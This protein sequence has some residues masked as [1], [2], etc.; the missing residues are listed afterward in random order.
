MSVC[1]VREALHERIIKAEFS[2]QRA[3]HNSHEKTNGKVGRKYANY[4]QLL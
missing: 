3:A 4:E 1:R 2:L